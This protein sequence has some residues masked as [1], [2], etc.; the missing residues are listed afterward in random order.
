MRANSPLQGGAIDDHDVVFRFH[1]APTLR[2]E[3]DVGSKTNFQVTG[4][5]FL[6]LT[7]PPPYCCESAP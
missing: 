3:R 4:L 6:P 7:N 5:L 1:H 2:F